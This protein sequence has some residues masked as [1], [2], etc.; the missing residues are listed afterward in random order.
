MKYQVGL[1]KSK[2]VVRKVPISPAVPHLFQRICPK[3]DGKVIN[4]IAKM[5]GI[6]PA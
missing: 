1:E 2:Y 3:I 5:I 6:I 4:E